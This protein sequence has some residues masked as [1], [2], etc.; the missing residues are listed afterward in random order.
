MCSIR[1][2]TLK[3]NEKGW[4]NQWWAD[5]ELTMVRDFWKFPIR[6]NPL[7]GLRRTSTFSPSSILKFLVSV[8]RQLLCIPEVCSQITIFVTL[9]HGQKLGRL[10]RLWGRERGLQRSRTARTSTSWRALLESEF[11]R[12]FL[13]RKSK[14]LDNR[15]FLLVVQF[16]M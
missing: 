8:M 6:I 5:F 4:E 14:R 15:S 10:P 16:H 9:C 1:W 7:A 11:I 12:G 3:L 13:V 2:E